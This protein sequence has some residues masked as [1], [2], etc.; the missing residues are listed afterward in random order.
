MLRRAALHRPHEF[1][2]VVTQALLPGSIQRLAREAQHAR[3]YV[4][5]LLGRRSRLGYGS[6]LFEILMLIFQAI[7]NIETTR[8]APAM[9]AG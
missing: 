7:Q 1:A 6:Q 3:Y 2:P 4:F 9:L 8:F 5:H